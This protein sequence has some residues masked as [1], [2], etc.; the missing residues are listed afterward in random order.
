[1][2]FTKCNFALQNL[3]KNDANFSQLARTQTHSQWAEEKPC[4]SMKKRDFV[5]KSPTGFEPG[6]S[7]L[8]ILCLTPRLQV[9]IQRDGGRYNMNQVLKS[10][11]TFEKR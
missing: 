9:M 2:K 10:A 1:M 5:K 3:T 7:R 8:Q 6:T 4:L 11:N